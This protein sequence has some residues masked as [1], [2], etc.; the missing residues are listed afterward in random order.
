MVHQWP[1][2]DLLGYPEATVRLQMPLWASM[3][4]DLSTSEPHLVFPNISANFIAQKRYCIQKMCMDLSIQEE[5]TVCKLITWFT[6]YNNSCDEDVFLRFLEYPA[7]LKKTSERSC[8]EMSAAHL[9][10]F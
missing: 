8:P 10:K 4:F 9:I 3:N 5:K 7:Y 1:V 6:Y 2:W